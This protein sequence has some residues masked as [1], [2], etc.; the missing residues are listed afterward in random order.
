MEILDCNHNYYQKKEVYWDIFKSIW[1]NLRSVGI[2]KTLLIILIISDLFKY[3]PYK[4][5]T[6][7]TKSGLLVI[8]KIF[9]IIGIKYYH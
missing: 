7:E 3:S 6:S 1:D 9:W 8:M 4:T 2:A 5:L